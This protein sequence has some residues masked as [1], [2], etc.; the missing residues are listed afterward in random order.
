MRSRKGLI[1]SKPDHNPDGLRERELKQRIMNEQSPCLKY[2]K[3]HRKDLS[4]EEII[5]IVQLSQQSFNPH[6]EIARKHRISVS[7]VHRLVQ[8]AI[9]SPS[10]IEALADKEDRELDLLDA[11]NQ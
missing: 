3:R 5:N 11:V 6:Q 2:K 7:L 8:D 1:H 9:K 10:K 4:H